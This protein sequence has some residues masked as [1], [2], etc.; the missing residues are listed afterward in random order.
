M[1]HMCQQTGQ[2]CL[3]MVLQTIVVCG[4]SKIK[5]ILLS[6]SFLLHPLTTTSAKLWH[7]C[8][9]LFGQKSQDLLLSKQ[10]LLNEET[11]EIDK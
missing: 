9:S 3:Q 5:N 11:K 10:E 8:F 1:T 2:F 6:Q 7:D 4:L